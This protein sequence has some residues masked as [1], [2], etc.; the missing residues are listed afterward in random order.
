MTGIGTDNAFKNTPGGVITEIIDQTGDGAGNIFDGPHAIAVDAAANV[1]V[2]GRGTDNAFKIPPPGL[3]DCNANGI[4]DE[5]I[6]AEIIEALKEI[7]AND[8]TPEMQLADKVQD[9][10]NNAMT[11]LDK[12]TIIDPPDPPDNQGAVGAIEGAVGDLCAAVKDGLLDPDLGTQLMDELAGLARGLAVVAINQAIAQG[13]DVD[14][15][16]QAL[17]DGDDFRDAGNAGD[18]IAFK[19]AVDKYKDALS[20]AEDALP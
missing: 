8:N 2:T 19:D 10:L 13:A 16:Q 6:L 17:A 20:A 12:L 11:A 14:S 4:P 3:P 7:I 15:A 1:F 18:C 9:A 5:C